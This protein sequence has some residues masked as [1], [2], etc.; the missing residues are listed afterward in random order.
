[1]PLY[2]PRNKEEEDFA[3][4]ELPDDIGRMKF[5]VWFVCGVVWTE[6]MLSWEE[7]FQTKC[8]PVIVLS[9]GEIFNQ[10]I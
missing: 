6:I 9:I 4:N 7:I 8:K 5:S 1:M 10:I 3:L 2:F